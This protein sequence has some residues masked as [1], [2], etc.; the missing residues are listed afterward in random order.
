MHASLCPPTLA[1][2]KNCREDL[3]TT[4]NREKARRIFQEVWNEKRVEKID[5]LVAANYVHHD[6]KSP[7]QKGIEA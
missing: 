6:V 7:D 3:M 1:E 4:D 2:I 5:E